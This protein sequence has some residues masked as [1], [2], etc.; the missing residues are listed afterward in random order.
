MEEQKRTKADLHPGA[1]GEADGVLDD[2]DSISFH[3]FL[4]HFIK[5]GFHRMVN[6]HEASLEKDHEEKM[7]DGNH[8][9]Q[10]ADPHDMGSGSEGAFRLR[11]RSDTVGVAGF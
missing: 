9:R 2:K 4:T 3:E 11:F 5:N 6:N 7:F 8:A 1:E 10:T